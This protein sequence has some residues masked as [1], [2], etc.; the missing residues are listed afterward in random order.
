MYKPI[1]NYQIAELIKERLMSPVDCEL[2]HFFTGSFEP[3]M[4]RAHLSNH[5]TFSIYAVHT[6]LIDG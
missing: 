1:Q 4:K 5:L 6:L 3:R 2:T